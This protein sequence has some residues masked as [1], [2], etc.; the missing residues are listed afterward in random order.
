MAWGEGDL[1]H[2]A[3]WAI[4]HAKLVHFTRARPEKVFPSRRLSLSYFCTPYSEAISVEARLK[5]LIWCISV[6]K[7]V[8][9][10]S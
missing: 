2:F 1:R 6:Q 7:W 10:V 4:E 3:D 5:L 9:M 8:S